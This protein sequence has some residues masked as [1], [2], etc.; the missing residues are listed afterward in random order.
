MGSVQIDARG[1][2]GFSKGRTGRNREW[3]EVVDCYLNTCIRTTL[4]CETNL[5]PRLG[6]PR[7]SLDVLNCNLTILANQVFQNGHV[8]A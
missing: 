5:A 7:A 8:I 6:F 4:N 3:A 2:T 1:L